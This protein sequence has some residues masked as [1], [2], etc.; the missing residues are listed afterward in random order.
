MLLLMEKML[1]FI[2]SM[3]ND[4]MVTIVSPYG[5]IVARFYLK[6]LDGGVWRIMCYVDN[7]VVPLTDWVSLVGMVYEVVK[8][9]LYGKTNVN[10]L[11]SFVY[12]CVAEGL[13]DKYVGEVLEYSTS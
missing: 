8:P 5:D 3:I 10:S 2:D 7:K 4:K 6:D 11:D 13:I 1:E 9:Y 12:E